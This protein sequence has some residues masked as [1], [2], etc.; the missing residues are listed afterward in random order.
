MS[1]AK[2][3]LVGICLVV[4][5]GLALLC[6]IVY[7]GDNYA[8]EVNNPPLLVVMRS[9]GSNQESYNR[10]KHIEFESLYFAYHPEHAEKL[11]RRFE[12]PSLLPDRD[13]IAETIKMFSDKVDKG[14]FIETDILACLVN[15]HFVLWLDKEKWGLNTS[16]ESL[17]PIIRKLMAKKQIPPFIISDPINIKKLRVKAKSIGEPIDFNYRDEIPWGELY[18]NVP[19]YER[20]IE[21][22][23]DYISKK[24]NDSPSPTD[25]N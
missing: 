21:R 19:R 4:M 8:L 25:L 12:N 7:K 18:Y 5:G 10:Y 9:R 1:V 20:L 3:T 22:Y 24:V 15:L 2:K 16:E 6:H 13:Y 23:A 17:A 11:K 14:D